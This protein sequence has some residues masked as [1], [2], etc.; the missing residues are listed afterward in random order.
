[1]PVLIF[2]PFTAALEKKTNYEFCFDICLL[3]KKILIKDD[4]DYITGLDGQQPSIS[5]PTLKFFE[6]LK[7]QT[8]T[9]ECW[10]QQGVKAAEIFCPFDMKSRRS[11]IR[12]VLFVIRLQ[13]SVATQH[14][15]PMTFRRESPRRFEA[16]ASPK[17]RR[18]DSP[19]CP[20]F[21]GIRKS[22]AKLKRL[23]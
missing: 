17:I 2:F 3:F 16:N 20:P 12:A 1:M 5:N 13:K 10:K 7:K 18:R 23:T 19:S 22:P 11:I 4:F 8:S 6:V 15:F 9:S 21:G 14:A